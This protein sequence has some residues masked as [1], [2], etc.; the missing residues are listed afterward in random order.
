M[1]IDQ[2]I[3]LKTRQRMYL[4]LKYTRV[5]GI[6]FVCEGVNRDLSFGTKYHTVIS[7]DG[8]QYTIVSF[9]E[10]AIVPSHL[11]DNLVNLPIL[12]YAAFNPMF[13]DASRSR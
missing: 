1:N 11:N 2:E 9:V 5:I 13:S 7:H 4:C 8:I 3:Q 10:P 6:V 12:P